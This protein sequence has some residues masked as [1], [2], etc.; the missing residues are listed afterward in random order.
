MPNPKSVWSWFASPQLCQLLKVFCITR[1]S[2]CLVCKPLGLEG[3]ALTTI[4]YSSSSKLCIRIILRI[5]TK[6]LVLKAIHISH[7]AW[8]CFMFTS[9][10][11]E[12]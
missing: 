8:K 7:K 11:T 10:K 5:K 12:F 4:D 9:L 1:V 3:V 2:K 6:F